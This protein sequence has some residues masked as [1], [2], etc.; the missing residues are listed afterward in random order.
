MQTVDDNPSHDLKNLKGNVYNRNSILQNEQHHELGERLLFQT[1]SSVTDVQ[2][3]NIHFI[4][5]C[6]GL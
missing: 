3:R 5:T 4:N 2:H 6:I 1:T